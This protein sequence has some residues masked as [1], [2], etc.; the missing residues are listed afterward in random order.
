MRKSRAVAPLSMQ[1]RKH[2]HM[3]RFIYLGFIK[4][5]QVGH[6]R[7]PSKLSRR[8]CIASL[9]L[10]RRCVVAA[11]KTTVKKTNDRSPTKL[12]FAQRYY[13]HI[14]LQKRNI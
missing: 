2:S 4:L 6:A 9:S 7:P 12:P 5:L 1:K 8:G 11:K 10:R 14:V 3:G 13:Y